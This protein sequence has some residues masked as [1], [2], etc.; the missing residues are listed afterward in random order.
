MIKIH[1]HTTASYSCQWVQKMPGRME[2][3]FGFPYCLCKRYRNSMMT[4]SKISYFT[5]S[6]GRGELFIYS[7]SKFFITQNWT[8]EQFRLCGILKA[9]S[10]QE[11]HFLS[12]SDLAVRRREQANSAAWRG[13]SAETPVSSETAVDSGL[14]IRLPALCVNTC[15]NIQNKWTM[16]LSSL[17]KWCVSQA[18]Y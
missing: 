14:C 8:T 15:I 9:M 13:K 6:M 3:M 2:W 1:Q 7:M 12:R 10:V 16:V 5:S 4:F 11:C 17:S 18:P